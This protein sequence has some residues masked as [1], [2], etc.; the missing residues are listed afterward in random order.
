MDDVAIGLTGPAAVL[1]ARLRNAYTQFRKALKL[2]RAQSD[3][4]SQRAL[5]NELQCTAIQ[6]DAASRA[7]QP[8]ELCTCRVL[9]FE[10]MVLGSDRAAALVECIG[11]VA[12]AACF[13]SRT[14]AR[15][16]ARE[17]L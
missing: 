13:I 14:R 17:R 11:T 4:G 16:A 5:L 3:E 15:I 8:A 12:Q 9:A 1:P 10:A 2:A 7:C 6:A